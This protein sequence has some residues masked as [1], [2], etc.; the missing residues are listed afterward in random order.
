MGGFN[1]GKKQQKKTSH[2][3]SLFHTF[4]ETDQAINHALTCYPH[5]FDNMIP[6]PAWYARPISRMM[7]CCQGHSIT[8]HHIHFQY[9]C[10]SQGFGLL[11]ILT[12][13]DMGQAQ[14]E[15]H[16]Q[17]KQWP[18]SLDIRACLPVMVGRVGGSGSRKV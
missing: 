5:G 18:T 7:K 17:R 15:G 14:V 6:F 2:N 13:S 8:R 3:S 4:H 9:L 1:K 11:P 12:A 16:R 10:L